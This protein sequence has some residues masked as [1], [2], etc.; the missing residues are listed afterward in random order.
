MG[1]EF[2]QTNEW[3]FAKSLDWHLLEYP[4]HR[5]LKEMVKTLNHIYT[6]ENALFEL[7]YES[8]G[9][10]WVQ[11]DDADNSVYV[12][13]RKWKKKDDV[14]LIVLNLTP[15]VID[16]KIGTDPRIEWKVIFNSD[17]ESFAGSGVEADIFDYSTEEYMGFD[18]NISIKLPPL[19]VLILKPNKIKPIKKKKI[20]SKTQ[21]KNIKEKK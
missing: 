6:S 17:E 7:Q 9:F 15:R 5:G 11:A 14:L 1:Y 4:V 19:A 12:Y 3:N 2:G 18:G 16:Y 8:D 20:I 21:T 10:Q 13:L